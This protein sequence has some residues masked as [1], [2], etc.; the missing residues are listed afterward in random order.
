FYL[1]T[2]V[3]KLAELMRTNWAGNNER[4]FLQFK[5]VYFNAYGPDLTPRV[6]Y[7]SV[8]HPRAVEPLLIYWQITGDK[9]MEEL[10][11]SWMDTWVD[12]ASRE[13]NGKP[14]GI[15]PSAIHWPDGS[16]SVMGKK[17]WKPEIY[18]GDLYGWPSAMGYMTKV[19]MLTYSMTGDEKYLEPIRSMLRIRIH[20]AQNPPETDPEPGSAAW[21]ATIGGTYGDGM[22]SF[23]PETVVKLRALLDISDYDDLLLQSN[24]NSY[25]KMR[26]GASVEGLEDELEKTVEAFRI[27]RPSYTSE[28]RYTDRVLYFN[29]YW[30]G[31][32]NGWKYPRPDTSLLYSSL[33]GDPGSPKYFPMYGVRWLTEPKAFAALVTRNN[34]KQ[35]EAQIFHFGDDVRDMGA[36]LYTLKAGDYRMTLYNEAGKVLSAQDVSIKGTVSRVAFEVP[37]RTLCRLHV[38]Q[39]K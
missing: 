28:V 31:D 9:D 19:L 38:G 23:L 7:D 10:F 24:I 34:T 6:S 8:Y 17:W 11:T 18:V 4:G 3:L 1:R 14:A 25:V 12:A 29:R 13:E 30:Y 36:D 22:N 39:K 20:Y 32:A 27:N 35:F 33:T 15:M 5:S 21:C 26:L 16:F 37:S 2:M